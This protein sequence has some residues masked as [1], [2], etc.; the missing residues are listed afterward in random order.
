MDGGDENGHDEAARRGRRFWTTGFSL[1]ECMS[2]KGPWIG[3][4]AANHDFHLIFARERRMIESFASTFI[5]MI[6]HA[7][8]RSNPECRP[9]LTEHTSNKCDFY[10]SAADPPARQHF[11][12]LAF[13]RC[14]GSLSRAPSRPPASRHSLDIRDKLVCHSLVIFTIRLTAP[15]TISSKTYREK[16]TWSTGLEQRN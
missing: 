15:G 4:S 10:K 11:N 7:T 14:K 1:L 6:I 3:P 2:A 16:H 8:S 9:V 13:L 12:F 5:A